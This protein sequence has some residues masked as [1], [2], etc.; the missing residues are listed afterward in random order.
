[1]LAKS[2]FFLPTTKGRIAFE[3]HGIVLTRSGEFMLIGIHRNEKTKVALVGI[4]IP[5]PSS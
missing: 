5:N 1:L 3:K 4:P 2:Q